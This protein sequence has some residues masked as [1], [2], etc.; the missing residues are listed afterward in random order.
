MEALEGDIKIESLMIQEGLEGSIKK[1]IVKARDANLRI[2]YAGKRE[3]DHITDSNHQGVIAFIETFN[4]SSVEDILSRADS[5]GEPPF[6]IILDGM[7]DPH[8]LGAITRTAEAAGSHGII[9]PRNRSAT[10]TETVVK[11]SAGAVFHIPVARV[12]N[13]VKTITEIKK[14]GLWVYGLDMDGTDF[15]KEDISGGVALVIGSEGNGLSRLVKEKCDVIISIPMYGKIN[16]L[17]ASNAAAVI[18][19][20]VIRQR[21]DF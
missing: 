14:K 2:K 1:I 13:L 16:S 3:L 19:Y 18:M 4:Y 21:D 10:V 11:T 17:N 7:E 9:I 5:L 6:I 12:T 15:R 20:E 8:N